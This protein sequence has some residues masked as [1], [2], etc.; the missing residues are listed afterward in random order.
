MKFKCENRECREFNEKKG[1]TDNFT[2]RAKPTLDERCKCPKCEQWCF[3]C[4]HSSKDYFIRSIDILFK[5]FDRKE[6]TESQ[7]KHLNTWK[8]ERLKEAVEEVKLAYGV[9]E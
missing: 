2:F 9:I 4:G 6:M 8:A 7:Y 5:K 1:Y 3:K